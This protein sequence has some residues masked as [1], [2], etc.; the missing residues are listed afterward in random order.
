MSHLGPQ[1]GSQQLALSL[2]VAGMRRGRAA[3]GEED[4]EEE[5]EEEATIGGMGEEE[6]ELSVLEPFPLFPFSN[7]EEKMF[8]GAVV[9]AEGEADG[10]GVVGESLAK[11][12]AT[13]FRGGSSDDAS[14]EVNGTATT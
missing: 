5:V 1:K 11:V 3:R 4:R 10:E 9:E 13:F 6:V 14:A 8:K 2:A 12:T 7:E